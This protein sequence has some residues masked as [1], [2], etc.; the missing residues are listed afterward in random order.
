MRERVIL[1]SFRGAFYP[2]SDS[3]SSHTTHSQ[4]LCLFSAPRVQMGPYTDTILG[5]IGDLLSL[6]P[7]ETTLLNREDQLYLF[8]TVSV[9]IISAAADNKVRARP[10][11]ASLVLDRDLLGPGVFTCTEVCRMHI[12]R[13][14]KN[15]ITKRKNMNHMDVI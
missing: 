5:Q 13:C 8:E 9:L 1:M 15:S 2:R 14:S 12:Y 3:E 10:R 6:E 11:S 4:R 7:S